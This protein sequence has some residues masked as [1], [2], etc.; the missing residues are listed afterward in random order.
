MASGK[1]WN[2]ILV[3]L[4]QKNP[5]SSEQNAKSMHAVRNQMQWNR[6]C[7]W[8]E[9]SKYCVMSHVFK[10][11]GITRVDAPVNLPHHSYI[12]LPNAACIFVL[13]VLDEGHLH[14]SFRK[15]MAEG[16]GTFRDCFGTGQLFLD[17]A[18]TN[19]SSLDSRFFAAI[20]FF[21]RTCHLK[22]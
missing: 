15:C 2:G 22:S 20:S 1:K 17:P 13:R 16:G 10:A 19:A 4:H 18:V 6:R 14:A 5:Y 8:L 11:N 3:A 7:C 12:T 21:L 9:S